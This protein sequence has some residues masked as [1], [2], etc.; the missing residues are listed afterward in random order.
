M[1]SW[2]VTQDDEP[3]SPFGRRQGEE[4]DYMASGMEGLHEENTGA[5]NEKT[6]IE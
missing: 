4:P 2:D 6:V 5:K 1:D 3:H